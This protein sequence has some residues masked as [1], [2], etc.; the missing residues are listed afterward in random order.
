M[1]TNT[2][3][4]PSP[5]NRSG[6]CQPNMYSTELWLPGE[7]WWHWRGNKGL[8]G[9]PVDLLEHEQDLW[10]LRNQLTLAAGVKLFYANKNT[11]KLIKHNNV[12]EILFNLVKL[13]N[14]NVFWNKCNLHFHKQQSSWA[15]PDKYGPKTNL[16]SPTWCSTSCSRDSSS[17]V[18]WVKDVFWPGDES[19][20]LFQDYR[21][22]CQAWR[23][24]MDG[25]AGCAYMSAKCIQP[26]RPDKFFIPNIS[27][28][29][30]KRPNFVCILSSG[31]QTWD[32]THCWLHL[33]NTHRLL[34]AVESDIKRTFQIS[35]Y[36]QDI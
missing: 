29:Y 13:R 17:S 11:K 15:S 30:K 3:P 28:R 34:L 1:L 8:H 18:S 10:T 35:N 9:F 6:H 7:V 14:Y 32:K 23:R 21:T 2:P 12:T 33:H 26:L 36:E 4:F 25:C 19:T 31:F 20:F 5:A 22:E 24:Q 16:G 27:R